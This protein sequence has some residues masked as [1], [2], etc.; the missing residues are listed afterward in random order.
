L[1][2]RNDAPVQAGS[3]NILKHTRESLVRNRR[4]GFHFLDNFLGL[5]FDTHVDAVSH[6][7]MAL[8]E[9]C[10]DANGDVVFPALCVLADMALGRT[11]YAVVDRRNRL[12]TINLQLQFTGV[13]PR[14]HLDAQSTFRT[15]SRGG[16]SSQGLTSLSLRSGNEEVCFGSGSFIVLEPPPGFG[17]KPRPEEVDVPESDL[18]GGDL[19]PVESAILDD[20][21]AALAHSRESGEPFFPTFLGI[22]ATR[23][24]LGAI[25][26]V[27]NTPQLANRV[28]HVQGGILLGIAE[29]AAR[30][31][32]PPGWLLQ[33]IT[34]CYVRPGND[35]TLTAQAQIV[36]LGKLTAAVRTVIS[37]TSGRA[38]LETLVSYVAGESAHS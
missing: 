12:A 31:A 13:R 15:F 8:G 14:G 18:R 16:L 25:C 27:K 26:T 21:R 11:V 4:A 23:N 3:E 36:H 32:L 17:T 35:T 28:G 9:H 1:N 38:V 34:A 2:S 22:K 20:A 29:I 7:S 10:T 6:A 30:A 37:D 24:S 33:G 5:S 19:S